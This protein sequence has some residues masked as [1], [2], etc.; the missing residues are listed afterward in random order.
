MLTRLRKLGEDRKGATTIEYGLILALVV[1]AA[2]G[3]IVGL[4]SSTLEMWGNVAD[5]VD[6]A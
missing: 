2:M 1:L 5:Q 6:K 4:A 3:A